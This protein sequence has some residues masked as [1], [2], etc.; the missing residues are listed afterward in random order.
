MKRH[1]A[2]L[3]LPL[4]LLAACGQQ[5]ADAGGGASGATAGAAAGAARTCG[6]QVG[7]QQAPDRLAVSAVPLGE[8]SVGVTFRGYSTEGTFHAYLVDKG[9][10]VI[11]TSAGALREGKATITTLCEGVTWQ[12][13]LD[14]QNFEDRVAVV[15]ST[16]GQPDLIATEALHVKAY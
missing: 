3:V 5:A 12:Q 14:H 11:G 8:E 1:A 16:P 13:V 9:G 6:Q 15:L 10:A 4:L 2:V 7:G